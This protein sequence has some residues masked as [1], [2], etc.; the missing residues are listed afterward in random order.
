MEEDDYLFIAHKPEEAF[1]FRTIKDHRIVLIDEHPRNFF[2]KFGTYVYIHDGS[3]FDPRPRMFH[4]CAFYRK[5]VIYINN[6]KINDGSWYRYRETIEDPRAV[7]N[8]T[9][10]PDDTIIKEFL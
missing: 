2:S 10:T 9:L 6:M 8:R 5:K 3:Y 1:K 7:K 4:E